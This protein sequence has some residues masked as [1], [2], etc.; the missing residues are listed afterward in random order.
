MSPFGSIMMEGILSIAASSMILTPR[1]VL[2]EPVIPMIAACVV[3]FLFF[4]SVSASVASI[5]V[6]STSLP[7]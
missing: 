4:R 7:R 5:V 1:P 2:P 3:K 6:L